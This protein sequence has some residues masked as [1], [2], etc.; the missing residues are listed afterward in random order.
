MRS[1]IPGINFPR[2]DPRWLRTPAERSGA[3]FPAFVRIS[4]AVQGALRQRIPAA[5]LETLESFRDPKIAYPL[6][7]YQ[8]SPP[9]RGKQSSELTYDVLNPLSMAALFRRA[10]PAL[11]ELLAQTEA[12]LRAADL[13]E[14]ANLYAPRRITTIQNDVQHLSKSRKCLYLL[15][16]GESALVDAL[17][18]LNGLGSLPAKE[19]ARRWALL[20]KRWNYQLRRLYPGKDFTCLA[21]ILLDAAAAALESDIAPM[22]PP[23]PSEAPLLHESDTA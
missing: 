9:H 12:R 13:P 20:G 17:V 8:A 3:F 5:L 2:L 18:Q 19:Q 1:I 10:K 15:I 6:L 4:L 21:G 14:A 22:Q 7:L 16:R 23:A 11:E